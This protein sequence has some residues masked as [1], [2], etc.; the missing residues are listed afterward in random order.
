MNLS[1]TTLSFSIIGG[2][3]SLFL[4][5][6]FFLTVLNIHSHCKANYNLFRKR[7]TLFVFCN[8]LVMITLLYVSL[9]VYPAAEGLLILIQ[10][11]VCSNFMLVFNYMKESIL[12]N[13]LKSKNEISES[14]KN[15]VGDPNLWENLREKVYPM[16]EIR[17]PKRSQFS[18]NFAAYLL[19][20]EGFIQ[21]LPCWI[22][23]N[24]GD[25]GTALKWQ[26]FKKFY[27]WVNIGILVTVQSLQFILID[28]A[29]QDI[30][31]LEVVFRVTRVLTT[32]SS[33]MTLNTFSG[34]FKTTLGYENFSKKAASIL[35]TLVSLNIIPQILRIIDFEF[36]DYGKEDSQNLVFICIYSFILLFCAFLQTV[37]FNPS[38]ILKLEQTETVKIPASRDLS[39]ESP[40]KA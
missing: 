25:F 32:M 34:N 33:M 4:S 13:C 14:F 15:I 40:Q 19:W 39:Q 29:D 21:I 17:W 38:N 10:I 1:H 35:V 26:R 2:I 30:G 22:R 20:L 8:Q 28:A 31:A 11:I 5:V 3:V 12:F 6:T 37:F 16:T 9:W 27:L 18:D 24:W 7:P 23:K 36:D